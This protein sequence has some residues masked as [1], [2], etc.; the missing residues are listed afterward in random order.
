MTD[1]ALPADL[2]YNRGLIDDP[3][4]YARERGVQSWLF[5]V[6][7]EFAATPGGMSWAQ[8]QESVHTSARVVSD[9]PRE[10]T[11]DLA[12]Q[13]VAALDALPRPTLVSCRTGPRG[14]AVAYLYA[15]LRQGATYEEVLQAAERDQAPFCASAEI[16]E[17]LRT[18]LEA[19][20]K[21]TLI[22]RIA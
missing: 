5:L 22:P 10:L 1:F 19:L 6:G 17:W 8:V 3:R 7:D 15:G 2:A 11:L 12:R 13:H 4:A 16:K 21:E 18:S 20:R 14:S 9:P